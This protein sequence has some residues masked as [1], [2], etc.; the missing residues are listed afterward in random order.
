MRTIG[1][2]TI[3]IGGGYGSF[4]YVG[5]EHDAE[6]MRAHKARWEGAVG[7]KVRTEDA[8]EKQVQRY[9]RSGAFSTDHAEQDDEGFELDENGKRLPVA[10]SAE[11]CPAG[12]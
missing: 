9:Q 7:K 2:W 12:A 3:T 8:S 4:Q 5:T 10:A 11:A 6:E 1:V